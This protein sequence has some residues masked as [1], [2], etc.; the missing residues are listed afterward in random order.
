MKLDLNR[1]NSTRQPADTV[2]EPRE[3]FR[4]LPGRTAKYAFPR[5]VQRRGLDAMGFA[6]RTQR[7]TLIKL[8]T[9]SGKT[10]VGLVLLKSCANEGV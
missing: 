4:V 5:D 10:V 3:I 8:N 2:V 6:R 7:D 9:G 1:L